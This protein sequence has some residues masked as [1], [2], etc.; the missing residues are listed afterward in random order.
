MKYIPKKGAIKA[1][2]QEKVKA[3][4][5]AIDTLKVLRPET[6]VNIDQRKSID[7]ISDAELNRKLKITPST[8]D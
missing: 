6:V 1:L 7:E 2:L 3:A 5:D 8:Q 4:K